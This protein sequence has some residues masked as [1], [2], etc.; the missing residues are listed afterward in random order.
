VAVVGPTGCGKS[1][2]LNLCA[3]LLS[4]TAGRIRVFGEGLAGLNRR[5][6]YLFQSDPLMPWRTSV[7]NVALGLHYRGVE[8]AEARRRASE[9]LERVGLAGR[10]HA[11]P[12]Q[13][14]GGMK[15]RVSLAQTLIA[16]S[17]SGNHPDGRTLQRARRADPAADGDRV[18]RNL[19]G[20]PQVRPLHHA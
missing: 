6:G 17:R 12:H 10:D 15:K 16:D 9:W 11:Y 8:R 19:G 2:I 20:E 4:P 14:S 1:T 13:L 5:A 7:E 3:G 18:A